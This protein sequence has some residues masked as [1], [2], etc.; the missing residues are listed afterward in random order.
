MNPTQSNL[1]AIRHVLAAYRS[2]D[3]HITEADITAAWAEFD[4][5]G[6]ALRQWQD[7]AIGRLSRMHSKSS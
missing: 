6:A 5:L 1:A 4:A 7:A 2:T 3:A